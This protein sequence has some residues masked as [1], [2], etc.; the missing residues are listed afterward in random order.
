M[1]RIHY[2]EPIF[3]QFIIYII[4][5]ILFKIFCR[6]TVSGRE[7]LTGLN[8]KIMIF[9]TNHSSE[10][11]GILLRVALPLFSKRFL[12]MYYVSRL[13]EF[14]TDSGWRK[15]L[16]GG[17][18]FNLLGAYPAYSGHQDYAYSLQNHIAILRRNLGAVCIFPEGKRTK[19][20]KL[21]SGH[22]GVAFLAHQ[23]GTPVIPVAINGLVKLTLRDF[24]L[25]RRKVSVNFGKAIDPQTIV[26]QNNP[27]VSDFKAGADYVLKLIEKML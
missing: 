1:R 3:F 8:K 5:L 10:W 22:G 26:P 11:D 23:T 20:G 13:R 18:F 19:D 16:Y 9:A 7:N 17:H 21:G 12:P 14:Y 15:I 25:G 6:F 2:W 4:T 24:I 27:G